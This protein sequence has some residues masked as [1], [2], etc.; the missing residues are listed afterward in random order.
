MVG[1][2]PEIALGG[3]GQVGAAGPWTDSMGCFSKDRPCH[4]VGGPSIAMSATSYLGESG[5][6]DA[7]LHQASSRPREGTTLTGVESQTPKYQTSYHR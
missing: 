5:R 7:G 3:S 1:T 4:R 6:S 2:D